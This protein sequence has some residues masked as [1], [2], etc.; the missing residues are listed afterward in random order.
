[1]SAAVESWHDVHAARIGGMLTVV[2]P[3]VITVGFTPSGQRDQVGCAH[4]THRAG[5]A[6]TREA[7]FIEV[8]DPVAILQ[9][10]TGVDLVEHVLQ[11]DGLAIIRVVRAVAHHADFHAKTLLAVTTDFVVAG[12]ALLVGDN[13][14]SRNRGGAVGREVR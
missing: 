4:V 10:F 7:D 1:M 6:Q 13:L 12:V 11:I 14:T 8:A 2:S 3:S 5:L 9:I